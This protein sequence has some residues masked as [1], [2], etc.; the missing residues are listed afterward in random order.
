[1]FEFEDSKKSNSKNIKIFKGLI[2]NNKKVKNHDKEDAKIKKENNLLHT[3]YFDKKINK[4]V[5]I[6][7]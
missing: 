3:F 5:T 6:K 4:Y 7:E 2:T 1:M